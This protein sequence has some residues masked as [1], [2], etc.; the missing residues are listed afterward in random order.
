[1]TL[2]QHTSAIHLLG[3]ETLEVNKLD[4]LSELSSC[5]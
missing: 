1:M 3:A 2:G 5:F 4:F